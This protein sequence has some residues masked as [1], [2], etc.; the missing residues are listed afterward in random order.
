M[1]KIKFLKNLLGSLLVFCL[2]SS[3]AYGQCSGCTT[4][5]NSNS[6]AN[7]TISS[8]QT[9]CINSG[10]TMSGS[11]TISGGVLCNNGKVNSLMLRAGLVNNYGVIT[12]TQTSISF[13]GRVRVFC[14]AASQFS[15][16]NSVSMSTVDS[17]YFNLVSGAR[18]RFA[19]NLDITANK[20]SVVNAGTFIVVGNMNVNNAKLQAINSS[21]MNISGSINLSN[22]GNKTIVNSGTVTVGNDLN[23]GGD[24][25]ST[26]TLTIQ[27]NNLFKIAS[28]LDC[29]IT[30]ADFNMDNSSTST[31]SAS[32][33]LLLNESTHLVSN[34]G[35]LDGLSLIHIADGS[36]ANTGTMICNSMTVSG[37]YTN[38]NYANTGN[39]T[40]NGILNNN[41]FIRAS[42]TFSNNGTVN[43]G[44]A[45]YLYVEDYYHQSGADINGP[46][47]ATS[48]TLYGAIVI[49]DASQNAGTI[50]GKVLIYEMSLTT[51]TA[52]INY[53]FDAVTTP[54]LIGSGVVYATTSNGPLGSPPVFYDCAWLPHMH[55]V[56]PNIEQFSQ[57]PFSSV[58]LSSV[59]FLSL[60]TG[61]PAMTYS[62]STSSTSTWQ[63]GSLAQGTTVNP[64]VT[65]T[66]TITHSVGGCSFTQTVTVPIYT[67]SFPAIQ[68]SIVPYF[69]GTSPTFSPTQT[70]ISGGAYSVSTNNPTLSI[71]PTTGVITATTANINQTYTIYYTIST[72]GSG[73]GPYTATTVVTFNDLTC[74]P[75]T[76]QP[77]L[78]MCPG[79]KISLTALT[80][81]DGYTWAPSSGMSCTA[82]TTATL[83]APLATTVYTLISTRSG[84]LCGSYNFT[85]QVR[86][87][88]DQEEIIGCCFSNYGA[89]V[90]LNS[91]NTYINVYC[92]L[93]NELGITTSTLQK[94]E[95]YNE[96]DVTVLLNWYHNGKN[97]LYLTHNGVTELFGSDQ[98][99]KG[100]SNTHFNQLKLE[101]NGTKSIWIDA[102]GHSDLYLNGNVLDIQ[103]YNFLMREK[104]ASVYRTNGYARTGLRGYFSYLMGSATSNPG[105]AYL[106][107][108]G[109]PATASTSFRYRPLVMF[110]NNGGQEDEVS[111]N[112]MNQPPSTTNDSA[113]INVLSNLNNNVN[114][115]S[116]SVIQT[117]S[118]FYH[119]IK[120]TTAPTGTV[121]NLILRSY[122]Q[123]SD[124]NFQS[125]AEWEKDPGQTL[126]WWG[127]TPGASAST[128]TTSTDPG[129]YG[130]VYAQA[131]GTL[132]FNH[133]PFVLSKGGFYVNTNSFGGPGT[134]ISVSASP[135]S[136]TNAATPSG[137]GLNNS[138]GTGNNSGNAGNGN[139]TVFAPNPVAG[140][141][142]MNIAPANDCAISG[143]IKFTIDQNG[144]IQPATV[145]YGLPSSTLYLGQLSEDVYTIDNANSGISFSATPK[146]LLN[147]C[148]NNITIGT[149][150]GNDFVFDK[151]ITTP[152]AETILV[153]IP[154][155]LVLT[156]GTF[157]I[158]DAANTLKNGPTPPQL[159]SGSNVITIS[160]PGSYAAGVYHFSFTVSYTQPLT[161][162]T[163]NEI[164]T[165]QFIIK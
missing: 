36:I 67:V 123:Q 38:N 122:Y 138:Y 10:V 140:D 40:V 4:T 141:Y 136:N 85:V 55:K 30:N 22:T 39:L 121:S 134:V 135:S 27:N 93:V 7:I 164:I 126:D 137:G 66:Y 110:N 145:L 109:A 114:N 118:V 160:S 147:E 54:S 165:G 9:V 13:T 50:T 98:K 152:S 132:N 20:L 96:G 139:P 19:N 101:G 144:N 71:N 105:K 108:M 124:G 26:T 23:T 161:S 142:V 57:C 34:A 78:Q 73:C 146:N 84:V 15:F 129:T 155:N 1:R 112:F 116:P 113:F 81:A 72:M 52:N 49:G 51:T 5:Y 65:V 103:N 32:G 68:Y 156:L 111:A 99:V 37:T 153:Y 90:T 28:D 148:V 56:V 18:V 104:N 53:G 35:V 157:Q 2:I 31:F 46:S 60:S 64:S 115:N 16:S 119:K 100:N 88:C 75:T 80:G 25:T 21:S 45:S 92:N 162:L 95:F 87:D 76:E 127:M 3:T 43:L 74:H 77:L 125:I 133:K 94:G 70:G 79:E 91:S 58:Y 106:F 63:P 8:G 154:N 149:S 97:D 59:L 151:S 131:N 150:S 42:N 33:S 11:V 86:S 130:L 29:S 107:P 61:T 44:Q 102:Y 158:Y 69:P 47:S 117:N 89:A 24:G 163:V 48:P 82:C 14:F 62:Y 17:L 12:N 41:S 120:N 83:T 6:G 128:N 143:K 159:V